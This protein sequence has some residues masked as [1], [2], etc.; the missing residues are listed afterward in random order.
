MSGPRKKYTAA[1]KAQRVE[2]ALRA[3]ELMSAT[4]SSATLIATSLFIREFVERDKRS[5]EPKLVDACWVEYAYMSPLKRTTSF[6]AEYL[7]VYRRFYEKYVDSKEAPFR[8]P[9]DDIWAANEPGEMNS[10]WTA[11]QHA[12]ELGMPYPIF[13]GEAMEHAAANGY[14][15]FPRPNQLYSDSLL[16]HLTAHWQIHASVERLRLD[17]WDER[18]LVTNYAGDPAQARLHDLVV[19]RIKAK[20]THTDINIKNYVLSSQ[21]AIPIAVA[22]DRLGGSDVQTEVKRA[23][24]IPTQPDPD[25]AARYIR[26]CIGIAYNLDPVVCGACKV[27]ALCAQVDAKVDQ[28]SLAAFGDVEPKRAADR[29]GARERQR[30][31]RAKLRAASESPGPDIT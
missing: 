6:T 8:C 20:P 15:Q 17:E 4:P 30:T 31:R 29:E 2:R 5:A 10:L 27:A 26:P 19:E 14:K 23:S 18:F 9:I 12:D 24:R 11:R 28:L 22:I 7:K 16:R 3:Q 13:L 25:Q 1:K 21:P